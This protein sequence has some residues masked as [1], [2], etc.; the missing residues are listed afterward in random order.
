[1]NE[2][3]VIKDLNSSALR[4]DLSIGKEDG[5]RYLVSDDYDFYDYDS[6][7]GKF[8]VDIDSL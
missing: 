7:T 6:T 5:L 4:I 2:E 8:K 3:L 1:M